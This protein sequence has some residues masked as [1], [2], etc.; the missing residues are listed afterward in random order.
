VE[1]TSYG[2]AAVEGPGVEPGQ[3]G[4]AG[5]S[6]VVDTLLY[7]HPGKRQRHLGIVR[8]LP[9]KRSPGAPVGQVTHTAGIDREYLARGLELDEAA[10]GI[11]CELTQ[12][13]A[14][15]PTEKGNRFVLFHKLLIARDAPL[16]NPA[17]FC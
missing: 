17:L 2:H 16:R 4:L 7:Q 1:P 11:S 14:L 3:V 8:G 6:R 13:T 12:K 15:R 5:F 9:C 10:Q